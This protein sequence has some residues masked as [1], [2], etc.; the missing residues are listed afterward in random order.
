[1]ASPLYEKITIDLGERY[2]RGKEFVIDA[3]GVSRV[4]NYIQSATLNDTSLETFWLLASELLKGGE[5]ILEMGPE[6]NTDWGIGV[7]E[8]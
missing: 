4:N 7:Y 6:R 5:L 8:R 3:R 2:E 1:M